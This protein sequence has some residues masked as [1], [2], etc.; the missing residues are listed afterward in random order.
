MLSAAASIRAWLRRATVRNH[1]QT[2]IPTPHNRITTPYT[3]IRC[4]E[5][6]WTGLF[7]VF[8]AIYPD[9]QVVGFAGLVVDLRLPVVVR[10]VGPNAVEHIPGIL[11]GVAERISAVLI[12]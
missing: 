10:V 2:F 5:C 3:I 4:S 11:S 8:A 1:S 7:L 12:G 6:N 9:H